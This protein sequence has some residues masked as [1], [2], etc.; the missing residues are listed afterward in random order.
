MLRGVSPAGI[1]RFPPRDRAL[2]QVS[3]TWR[4]IRIKYRVYG[5]LLPQSRNEGYTQRTNLALATMGKTFALFFFALGQFFA[6]PFPPYQPSVRGRV[7]W[8][9]QVGSQK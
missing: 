8:H 6:S 2:P 5:V 4:A 1:I 7:R 9:M 3:L